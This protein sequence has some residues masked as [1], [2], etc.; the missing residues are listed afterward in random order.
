MRRALSSCSLTPSSLSLAAALSF[1]STFIIITS[2]Y[3]P[4]VHKIYLYFH[5][6]YYKYVNSPATIINFIYISTAKIINKSMP[7]CHQY[8]FYLYFHRHYHKY[9]YSSAQKIC[10]S[11][12]AD[13]VESILFCAPKL[14]S[15]WFPMLSIIF[16]LVAQ[17]VNAFWRLK[18]CR[19]GACFLYHFP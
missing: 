5:R 1:I 14:F 13:L 12:W 4:K 9:I 11:Q 18:V 16:A 10:P 19:F 8:K 15:L 17:V 7:L 6:H 3:I 2:I